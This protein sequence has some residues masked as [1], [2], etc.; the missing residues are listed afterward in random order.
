M[1]LMFYTCSCFTT[2]VTCSFK[3]KTVFREQS[4]HL[5]PLFLWRNMVTLGHI[6]LECIPQVL[7][8]YEPHVWIIFSHDFS[9]LELSFQNYFHSTR[10]RMSRA[11]FHFKNLIK[12]RL[13]SSI[14][15][16]LI[17]IWKASFVPLIKTCFLFV[18]LLEER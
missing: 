12:F 14:G 6:F 5:A 1:L 10:I 11:N 18:L 17:K 13:S 3:K 4:P 9:Q 16:W 2:S 8:I 7:L 15:R